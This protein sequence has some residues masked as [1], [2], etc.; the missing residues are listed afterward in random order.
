MR[1]HKTRCTNVKVPDDTI[2]SE[3]ER[4]GE[5]RASCCVGLTRRTLAHLA[6]RRALS[7][8]C[9]FAG[10]LQ[11]QLTCAWNKSVPT[12]MC[13]HGTTAAA[14]YRER[15]GP[16]GAATADPVL[17]TFIYNNSLHQ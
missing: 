9:R 1:Y 11:L 13:A 7:L 4:E 10:S 5:G 2:R 8:P 12:N 16:P 6:S 17:L 3:Q 15:S 14:R